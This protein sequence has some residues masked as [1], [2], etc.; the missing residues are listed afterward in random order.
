MSLNLILQPIQF[1]EIVYLIPTITS[2]S[3]ICMS[4]FM[5]LNN[6]ILIC[7]RIDIG[8]WAL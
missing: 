3:N 5:Y 2:T 7:K 8:G 6:L 4:R 1:E